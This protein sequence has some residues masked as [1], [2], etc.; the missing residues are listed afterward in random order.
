LA[1]PIRIEWLEAGEAIDLMKALAVRGLVGILER[2][3]SRHAVFVHDPHEE[4]ERLLA[5]VVEAL[6]SWLAD[7]GR[8]AVEVRVGERV[9]TVAP[10]GD[11]RDALKPRL[12]RRGARSAPD[13]P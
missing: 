13:L 8:D 4:T 5:E 12:A 6:E 9:Q 7:R 11:V 2:E 3:G 10:R 1:P